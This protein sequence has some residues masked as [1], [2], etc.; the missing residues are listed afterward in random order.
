MDILE[1][2]RIFEHETQLTEHEN[3]IAEISDSVLGDLGDLLAS[4]APIPQA[5][6]G[7][8]QFRH[9]FSIGASGRLPPGGTWL[10]FF[11]R[12]FQTTNQI[13]GSN[14]GISAGN[15]SISAGTSGG[16]QLRICTFMWRIE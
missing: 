7:I 8:G 5:A 12:S 15:S 11:I 9:D 10:W 4:K 1:Q 16:V 13:E 6:E 3:K 14:A 2:S